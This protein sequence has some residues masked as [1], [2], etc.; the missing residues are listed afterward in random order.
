MKNIKLRTKIL[1]VVLGIF[2]IAFTVSFLFNRSGLKDMDKGITDGAGKEMNQ[3]AI[4]QAVEI[5]R[6]LT[7]L[8]EG[9]RENFADMWRN[10]IF[11]RRILSEK[12][13]DKDSEDYKNYLGII[14]IV[15][16][17]RTVGN[18]AKDLGIK[19][20]VP[21]V[22]PRN[23]D[24][25]P[26][27]KELK[28]L[29][30]LKAKKIPD[31]ITAKEFEGKILKELNP[32]EKARITEY[33]EKTSDSSSYTR[34]AYQSNNDKNELLKLLKK[35]GYMDEY[36]D[37]DDVKNNKVIYYRAVRLSKVCLYCHGDPKR[38][39]EY[40]GNNEGK[41]AT[42]TKMENWKEGEIH[43]AFKITLDLN[44][45]NA[46][47]ADSVKKLAKIGDEASSETAQ[48]TLI[49]TVIVVFVGLGG[50]FLF[51]R[52]LTN[53]IATIVEIIKDVAKG[54]FRNRVQIKTKDE[55]GE[56][57]HNIN[58][59]QD[60]LSKTLTQIN[61]ISSNLA[62]SSEEL[63]STAANL[64][65]GSQTQAANVE[66]TVATLHEFSEAIKSLQSNSQDMTVQGKE[67]LEIAKASLGLIEDAVTGM[68]EINTSS[69]KIVEIVKV[70]NDIADQTN[71]LSLNA[72]IEA[73]RAGEHGRGFAVVADEISKLA[74][75]SADSTKT[76]ELLVKESQANT[77]KGTEIVNKT[78]E[79]FKEILENVEKTT[80]NIDLINDV[81]A[82]Q[83]KGS[84]QIQLAVNNVNDTTQAQSAGLEEMSANFTELANHAEI[85][86]SMMDQFELSDNGHG[87]LLGANG[88]QKKQ[89]GLDVKKGVGESIH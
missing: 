61:E 47:I 76:I 73:A 70:I 19:F 27:P 26:T 58:V 33:Y 49:I 54:N 68:K 60:N 13:K 14:P 71:L 57:S 5:G 20:K 55:V 8:A 50:I 35:A 45:T 40:W 88:D 44:K 87:N 79:A 77:Q 80:S 36:V 1:L 11:D 81:L 34:T 25:E 39:M 84:D 4:K 37:M 38:S 17:M 18:K 22:D 2:S 32:T 31:Q 52:Y 75:K 42:G 67:T 43:G 74:E 23:E 53:P 7:V 28:V 82:Q 16:S 86:K 3:M 72:A 21:K 64:S 10:K 48:T 89:I 51:I 83:S 66:E 63:N 65:E 69:D 9:V 62:T 85:M 59:M 6:S 29:K 30:M 24:N 15:A 12:L 78:G 46:L 41:D 56:I